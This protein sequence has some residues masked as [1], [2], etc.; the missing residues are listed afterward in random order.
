MYLNAYS[1]KNKKALSSFSVFLFI[2]IIHLKKYV[3]LSSNLFYFSFSISV[4]MCLKLFILLL[5]TD[6][7]LTTLSY[8][9]CETGLG[10]LSYKKI[11]ITHNRFVRGI[12]MP[13]VIGNS[14]LIIDE[15]TPILEGIQE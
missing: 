3:L 13:R 7:N 15:E 4:L 12:E 9:T 1:H 2:F 8:N 10:L 14:N 5:T 6:Y 11:K